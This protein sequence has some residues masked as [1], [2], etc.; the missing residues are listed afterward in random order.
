MM[1]QGVENLS[2]SGSALSNPYATLRCHPGVFISIQFSIISQSPV[3][4]LDTVETT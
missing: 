3:Y 1:I 2:L 4:Q